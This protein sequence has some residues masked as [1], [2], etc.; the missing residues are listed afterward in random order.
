MGSCVLYHSLFESTTTQILLRAPHEDAI[1]RV[2]ATARWRRATR[3]AKNMPKRY[4]C[5]RLDLLSLWKM[6]ANILIIDFVL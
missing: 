2:G 5:L 3:S 6:H 4:I 1:G